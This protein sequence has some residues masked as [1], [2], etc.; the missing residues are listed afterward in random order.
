MDTCIRGLGP[1]GQ[2]QI[3]HGPGRLTFSRAAGQIRW[4]QGQEHV[5]VQSRGEAPRHNASQP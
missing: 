2:K 4:V 1:G 3:L 5:H